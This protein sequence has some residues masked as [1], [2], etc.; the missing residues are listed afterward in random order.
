MEESSGVV[1]P[2][3]TLDD[4]YRN[5]DKLK[6]WP[7]IEPLR[8]SAGYVY[9]GSEIEKAS[10]IL[11]RLNRDEQPRTIVCHDMK[12]GYLEDRF[13]NGSSDP[14]CYTFYH[15]SII[16]IFIY[17]SHHMVTIPPFGWI[18]AAH[19]HG[20]KVLGTVITEH[21]DGEEIWSELL[22]SLEKTR[23]FA[24]ALITLAKFYG[25]E[26]W[27]LNV[28]NKIKPED[29]ERLQ[30]FVRYLTNGLRKDVEYSE[31][32]WYDSIIHD[33]SLNWQN[34]L[35]EKNQLFFD[36]CDGIFLNYNWSD[37]SLGS[38]REI[39][40]R[41]GRLRDIYVGLDVWGRGCPGGGGFN[42]LHALER[43]RKFNLSVAI[44]APG[45]THENFGPST[46]EKIE[47][48]FWAQL[49]PLLYIHVPIYYNE[50]FETSFCRG[51]GRSLYQSG[52]SNESGSFFNL[53]L[54]KLQISVPSLHLKFTYKN[55]P[56]PPPKSTSSKQQA[57]ECTFETPFEVIKVQGRKITFLPK[58]LSVSVNRTDF[59]N[60]FSYGGGG[61][62][63]VTTIHPQNYHR[64]FLTH[65]EF[66]EDVKATL[67]YRESEEVLNNNENRTRAPTLVLI[68]NSNNTSNFLQANETFQ[69]DT[70]WRKSY[71]TPNLRTI[72]EIAVA[73]SYQGRH[74]L[75]ELKI[76]PVRHFFNPVLR[77]T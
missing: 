63:Q 71:Y 72:N 3:S 52:E 47:N 62:L 35:N 2:F 20:V 40:A 25:F 43:I 53:N 60:D 51:Y 11:T 45:W 49:T 69:L 48:I 8:Q 36:C 28:E 9:P 19:K 5:L 24:D 66:S 12:G 76:E 22:S 6:P 50:S 70:R 33:G 4:L 58:N 67:I 15:W 44:F 26:G 73:F 31:V 42:S 29:I 13:I 65:L 16:D 56:E 10:G 55:I 41:N 37:E 61:C 18:N 1:K 21:K 54:Q 30:F 23:K 27:L 32:I 68:N 46:F 75:G 34:Q 77:L 17:F 7:R 39:A 14:T 74:Y 57:P 59:C 64:L 38:T